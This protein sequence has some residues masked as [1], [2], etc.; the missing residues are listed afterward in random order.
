MWTQCKDA[1]RTVLSWRMKD[2]SVMQC[3]EN[4]LMQVFPCVSRLW[5]HTH[6]GMK[7][8]WKTLSIYIWWKKNRCFSSGFFLFFFVF[9]DL[10]DSFGPR[11]LGPCS[12]C[13]WLYCALLDQRN[14]SGVL[15]D[16]L[17]TGLLCTTCIFSESFLN[18]LPRYHS[19][20]LYT[21][22][23]NV[24]CQGTTYRSDPSVVGPDF[25]D[26][27]SLLF[28]IYIYIFFKI[29]FPYFFIIN[30]MLLL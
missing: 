10:V 9:S 17:F 1:L 29:V 7:F 5:S 12:Q 22:C 19:Y 6:K 26:W 23:H 15:R 24:S 4:I 16:F 20:T 25:L 28:N 3:W 27:C 30:I 8:I 2:M 18:L 21:L 13:Y 11:L 14:A